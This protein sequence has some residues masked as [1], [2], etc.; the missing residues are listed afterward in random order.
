MKLIKRT[1]NKLRGFFPQALPNGTT[2]F[3][4]W[5]ESFFDTYDNMPTQDRES[6]RYTLCS[7]IMHLGPTAAY[8]SKYYFYLTIKA[9]AAKQVA[10][11]VF[12]D[13]KQA[14]LAKQNKPEATTNLSVVPSAPQGI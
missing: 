2:A 9:A 7:I 11:S 4:A 1:I 5:S 6:T 13:I 14:Q 12:Y 8:K 3:N 10:G